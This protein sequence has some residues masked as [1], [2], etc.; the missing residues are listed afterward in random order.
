MKH[1]S[2]KIAI[3]F[4]TAIICASL[5]IGYWLGQR[6][7]HPRES[8][9]TTTHTENKKILYWYDPMVPNQHF[10]Q[11]GKSPFMDMQLRPRYVDETTNADQTTSADEINNNG[12]GI[13]IDARTAQNFGVRLANV[14]RR[15]FNSGLDAVG[16]IEFNQRNVAIVQARADGYVTRV[17][18]RAPGDVIVSGAALADVLV[19]EWA[20]AQNEFLALRKSGDGAL[21]DAA[22]ARLQALGMSNALIEKIERSGSAQTTATITAPISGSLQS[23]NARTG[24]TITRGA[25]LAEINDLSTV[26]L[27]ASIP[28]SQGAQ[29][30]VGDTLSA[31][32]TAQPEAEIIGRVAAV[33]PQT[34]AAS[35]TLTVR[36]EF[37]NR[38]GH[39]HPGQF[40]R[41]RLQRDATTAVLSIPS[42]AIIRS[43]TRNLVIRAD[44]GHYRAVEVSV[45]NEA[46]GR[47]EI[48]K[49]LDEGQQ[50]V[51]SSQFLID[52]EA[53]LSSA[54]Q[55]INGA[56]P[57]MQQ[58]EKQP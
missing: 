31:Q 47:S 58:E 19:P 51:A 6:A 29:I 4:V 2:L 24:M 34:D 33:L 39:L 48:L 20:A 11:P 57:S 43:G 14:E 27:S 26:W 8:M 16:T 38:A 21:I 25:T 5:L 9:S 49:G 44:N 1:G 53:N 42:E 10:D 40:A 46:Q 3:I 52:S 28:E 55:R 17:Y 35:R 15:T 45:G 41:I 18:A 7:G 22:R 36:A 30:N 23:L 37:D 50:V 32:L 54:L 12:N 56:A 13:R